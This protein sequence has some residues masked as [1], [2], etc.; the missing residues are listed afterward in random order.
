MNK[1]ILKILRFTLAPLCGIIFSIILIAIFASN[2]AEAFSSFFSGAFT[3]KYYFGNMLNCAGFLMLAGTGAAISIVSGNMN[4]GGEGQIYFGG[5][6]GGLILTTAK[7]PTIIV[8]LIALLSSIIC[9]AFLACLSALL[10][11]LRGAEPLLTSFLV[12]AA[13]I[14]IIDGFIVSSNNAS[15]TNLL[16]L[17]YIDQS[18]RF[19]RILSP[20]PL[21]LSFFF[22]ILICVLAWFYLTKTE[23]G[24]KMKIWGKAPLYAKYCGYNSRA[25]SYG[26]LCIS[27]A[28]HGLTGFFA[29]CGTYF[30][31]LKGFHDG[32]G[33]NALSCALISSSNPL[34]I[35]PVSL[36]LG[37][38]YTST[39]RVALTQGF[40]FDI[41]GIIQGVVLFS[42]SIPL[43]I[44][45]GDN[46]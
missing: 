39:D 22:S 11:E 43:I 17:P 29:V 46:K 19:L 9:S 16:A 28:L 45:K 25:N 5:F 18:Y 38:L 15:Q 20:S 13:I 21:T 2:S 32:L 31:C 3:S 27:G 26:S 36:V 41:S 1:N 42:I 37:W 44:K 34:A 33:W 14:P 8:F 35:I 7:G 30:T 4:L 10:K 40:G 6:I 12:S 23:H 24:Y